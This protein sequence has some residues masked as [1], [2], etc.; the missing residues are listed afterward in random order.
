MSNAIKHLLDFGIALGDIQPAR[1]KIF[2]ITIPATNELVIKGTVW[3]TLFPGT[4]Q[5]FPNILSFA[6]DNRLY[7]NF[8]ESNDFAQ[9]E[10]FNLDPKAVKS[11]YFQDKINDVLRIYNAEASPVDVV[12]L[13]QNVR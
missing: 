1:G 12:I 6:S 2:K 5:R 9:G 4:R 10:S 11:A 7:Y 13:V 8:D 3:E